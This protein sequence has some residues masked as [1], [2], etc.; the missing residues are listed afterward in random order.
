M[1]TNVLL[2]EAAWG[3]KSVDLLVGGFNFQPL[4]NIIANQ[5]AIP[6][7]RGTKNMFQHVSTSK[8]Y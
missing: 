3:I 7:T 1:I 4:R 8:P 2:V 6:N 5:P